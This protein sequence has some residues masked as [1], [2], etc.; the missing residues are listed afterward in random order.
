MLMLMLHIVSCC[1]SGWACRQLLYS[2]A[3]LGNCG[4]KNVCNRSIFITTTT[5]SPSSANDEAPIMS[6]IVMVLPLLSSLSVPSSASLSEGTYLEYT[7][8]QSLP[9]C[10]LHGPRRSIHPT[11]DDLSP[12]AQ[13]VLRNEPEPRRKKSHPWTQTLPRVPRTRSGLDGKCIAFT[14][15]STDKGPWGQRAVAE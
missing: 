5:T 9:C 8:P 2:M 1:I 4:R 15:R 12:T 10:K 3:L 13:P 7:H 11:R 6:I 14:L